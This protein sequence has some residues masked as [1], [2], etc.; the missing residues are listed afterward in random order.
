MRLPHAL[1]SLKRIHIAAFKIADDGLPAFLAFE[2]FFQK[3]E[4]HLKRLGS[5]SDIPKGAPTVLLA[6]G[7][8]V[9][10]RITKEQETPFEEL[11][12]QHRQSE[13]THYYLPVNDL[14][15]TCFGLNSLFDSATAYV[16]QA[17]IVRQGFATI[18]GLKGAMLISQDG[19][20]I[21]LPGVVLENRH[22]A[23][24]LSPASEG[25]PLRLIPLLFRR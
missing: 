11:I 9:I 3:G 19:L 1:Y 16:E 13:F 20:V 25:I 2:I 22:G 6:Y 21:T 10:T 24:S 5:I 18:E 8:G 4:Y 7:S 23:L 12:P 17:N 15:V 14:K